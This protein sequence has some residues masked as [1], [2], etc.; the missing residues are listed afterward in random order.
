VKQSLEELLAIPQDAWLDDLGAMFT[1][2]Y[3]VAHV[4]KTEKS[5]KLRATFLLF[6]P[7]SFGLTDA[8]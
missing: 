6:R 4:V 5:T 2:F 8:L 7:Y 3:K 1:L